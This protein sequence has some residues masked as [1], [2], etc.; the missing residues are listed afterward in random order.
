M[1]RF[2]TNPTD[3]RVGVASV[4]FWGSDLLLSDLMLTVLDDVNNI[5]DRS[6]VR[7]LKLRKTSR[8]F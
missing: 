8:F 7:S 5:S 2:G 1:C 6:R 4:E 3:F